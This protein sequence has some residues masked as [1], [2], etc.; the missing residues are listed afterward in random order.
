MVIGVR[1]D[2]VVSNKSRQKKSFISSP[3][4]E[5]ETHI[6]LDWDIER[7]RNE[8]ASICLEVMRL[9]VKN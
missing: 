8:L 7:E 9:C 4:K 3:Q 1:P 6:V 5:E 2:I